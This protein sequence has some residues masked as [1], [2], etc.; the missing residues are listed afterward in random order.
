MKY[1][2]D[3]L[4]L[5]SYY[6]ANEL[7]LSPDFIYLIEKEIYRRNLTDKLKLYS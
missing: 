6:K 1:L 3:E 4:L 5:E 2:S 7:N